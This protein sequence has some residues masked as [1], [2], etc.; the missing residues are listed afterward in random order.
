MFE[1]FDPENPPRMIARP[2]PIDTVKLA[3]DLSTLAG[4]QIGSGDIADAWITIGMLRRYDP[5]KANELTAI[6]EK[7]EAAEEAEAEGEIPGGLAEPAERAE[8]EPAGPP[9]GDKYLAAPERAQTESAPAAEPAGTAPDAV[10]PEAAGPSGEAGE[11][12]PP[13]AEPGEEYDGGE[14][15][16]SLAPEMIDSPAAPLAVENSGALTASGDE[17]YYYIGPVVTDGEPPPAAAPAAV[18]PAPQTATIAPDVPKASPGALPPTLWERGG[19]RQSRERRSAADSSFR[20]G[21]F[22]TDPYWRGE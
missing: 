9:V 17:P 11:I 3:R 1:G 8:A 21:T 15:P 20:R 22:T 4:M 7:M 18:A 14:P 6:L 16:V 2:T 5:E 13:V 19:V 12:P 10:V